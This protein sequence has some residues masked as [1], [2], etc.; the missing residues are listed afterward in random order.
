[1]TLM[2]AAIFD[3]GSPAGVTAAL[4]AGMTVIAVPAADQLE[5]PSVGRAHA[6]L[7]SLEDFHPSQI[8]PEPPGQSW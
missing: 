8:E 6:V 2:K 4:A 7:R 5:H 1:M 3:M